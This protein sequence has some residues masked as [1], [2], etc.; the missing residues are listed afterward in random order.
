MGTPILI[1][2]PILGINTYFALGDAVAPTV[3]QDISDFLT[4]VDPSEDTD[5]QDATTFRNPMKRMLAGMTEVGY[6]LTGYF[7][8]EAHN[9]FAPLR[10]MTDVA[11]EY[12]PGGNAVGDVKI[13]GTCTV[14]SYADPSASVDG[15]NGFTV[16]LKIL[17]RTDGVFP[18]LAATAA[19]PPP[20]A[21]KAETPPGVP[22]RRGTRR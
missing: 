5:E 10:G 6:T 11:F 21:A 13:S 1:G 19:A 9:F 18:V 15:V 2:D 16:E 8:A 17:T 12:G 22:V 20:T 7:S 3:V 4:A 14:M